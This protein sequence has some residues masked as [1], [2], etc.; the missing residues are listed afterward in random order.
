MLQAQN[1]E[2][3]DRNPKRACEVEKVL[4]LII[5]KEAEEDPLA[6]RETAVLIRRQGPNHPA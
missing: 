1:E 2:E 4:R 5:E 6:Y 3:A